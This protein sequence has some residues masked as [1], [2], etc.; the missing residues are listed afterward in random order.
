[1]FIEGMLVVLESTTFPG[2]TNDVTRPILEAQL[3]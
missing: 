1:M 2:T 3:E